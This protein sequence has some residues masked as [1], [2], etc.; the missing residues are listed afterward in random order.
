MSVQPVLTPIVASELRRPQWVDRAWAGCRL[1]HYSIRPDEAYV[2]WIKWCTIICFKRHPLEMGVAQVNPWPPHLAVAG[3]VSDSSQNQSFAALLF[4]LQKLLEVGPRRVERVIRAQRSKRLPVVLS[5]EKFQLDISQLDGA[6]RLIA[7]LRYTAD[8]R[9]LDCLQPCVKDLDRGNN[10]TIVRHGKGGKERRTMFAGP[11]L[12]RPREHLPRVLAPHRRN[13]V[14]SFG[15]APL[16]AA[17]R[18]KASGAG[19]ELWW[20]F[21]ISS[22]ILSV[23]PRTGQKVRLYLHENAV[24]RASRGAVQISGIGWRFTIQGLRRTIETHF[25]DAGNEIRS[26]PHELQGHSRV[27][28][29]L[30]FLHV[31]NNGCRLVRTRLYR[32]RAGP[33]N[34]KLCGITLSLIKGDNK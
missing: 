19:K 27:E 26:V 1:R 33:D 9:P 15:A 6:Y 21:L 10:M 8:L 34:H 30:T 16:P 14:R 25:L 23:D 3:R 7:L 29:T 31:P 13:F 2:A 18:R 32:L 12:L 17:F 28:T 24:Y 20:Q 4:L 11:V 5:R 22:T